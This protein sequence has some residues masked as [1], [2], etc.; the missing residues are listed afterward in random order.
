MKTLAFLTL[1]LGFAFA[2]NA[3]EKKEEKATS[4]NVATVEFPTSTANTKD[5]ERSKLIK[6]MKAKLD[7]TDEQAVQVAE[8]LSNEKNKKD[9]VKTLAAKVRTVLTPQQA[10][11]LDQTL[12]QQ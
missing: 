9:D 1:F 10:V 3:Q 8:I 12:A 7:L 2:A 4:A 6:V 11:K 5:K